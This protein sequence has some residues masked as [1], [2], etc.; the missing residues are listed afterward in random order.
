MKKSIS[1]YL[2]NLS[3]F[4]RFHKLT[5]NS[6]KVEIID[7]ADW[8]KNWVQIY[9][10]SYPRFEEINLPEARLS[11]KES[12]GGVLENRKSKREFSSVP[13]T[14][15]QLSTLLRYGSGVK[16]LNNPSVNRYY[17]SAGGRYPLET[18]ILALNIEKLEKGIYHYYVKNHSLEKLFP[19][20]KFELREYLTAQDSI[21]DAACFLI[22]TALF[23][24]TAVK[25]GERG[26]RHV[27]VEAGHM[28]QNYYL[29]SSALKISCS[30]LGGYRDDKINKLLEIDGLKE[31]VVYVMALGKS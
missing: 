7:E 31:T 3:K 20:R 2:D 16:D 26:Y 27:L 24:R 1:D 13:L 18:Y 17:P 15:T 9:S 29:T 6:S 10:K 4:E 14:V 5:K 12:L 30:A 19:L 21:G 8:P 28:A 11:K 25:Y 22:I 23:R